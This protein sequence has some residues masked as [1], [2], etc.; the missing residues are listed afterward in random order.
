M[1]QESLHCPLD[2][3]QLIAQVRAGVPEA[4]RRFVEAARL[5]CRQEVAR[6][7]SR[8]RETRQDLED[9][10][11][12]ILLEWLDGH[13]ALEQWRPS[14][15][16]CCT[17]LRTVA[18][19]RAKDLLRGRRLRAVRGDGSPEERTPSPA[20]S[21]EQALGE[22]EI[23]ELLRR[24]LSAEEYELYALIFIEG[25]GA[26]ELVERQG[27]NRA[28]VYQAKHRLLVKIREL[29]RGPAVPAET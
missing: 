28:A 21:P 10:V 12:T 25:L 17:Y 9:L 16:R 1:A 18:R 6:E 11:Q 26:E 20:P 5:L 27:R 14:L 13:R 15:G 24:Q 2:D 23:R 4:R 22:A 29:L 8:G 3:P 7:L 19:N